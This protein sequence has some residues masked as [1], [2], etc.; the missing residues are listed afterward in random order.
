MLPA[1]VI[2]AAAGSGKSS[3]FAEKL[4]QS[5]RSPIEVYVPT[6]KLA[7][8][9][10][11]NILRH[12]PSKSIVILRGR[13]AL[14]ADGLPLCSKHEIADQ[15]V[16]AGVAVYPHL[17]LVRGE[18]NAPTIRCEYYDQCPYIQQFRL[19]EIIIYTHAHIPLQRSALENWVP[20]AV[21]I[22]ESFFQTCI[23]QFRLPLSLLTHPSLPVP[24]RALCRDIAEGFTQGQSVHGRV[25]ESVFSDEFHEAKKALQ[26]TSSSLT[27]GMTARHQKKLIQQI[28]NFSPISVLLD[29]L[30]CAAGLTKPPQSI[31]FDHG[32]G[33]LTI[34]HRHRITRFDRKDG[35]HPSIH[36][37][38]ASAAKTIIGRFF[39][40]RRFELI[41]TARNAH[42]TQ[43]S[44][45][46][47][48][49]TSLVPNSNSDAGSAKDAQTRL[50]EIE[51]LVSRLAENHQKVLV[52]GPV[53]IV[54]NPKTGAQPLISIPAHCELAHFNAL[55]GIDR[56]KDFDTAIVVGRNEPP[57]KAVEDMARALYYDDPEPLM[58]TG[59]WI[60][61]VRG[62]RIKGQRTGTD[63]NIHADSRVQDVLEQLREYEN[64]QAVDRL[65][66]VHCKEEKTLILLSNIPLDIDVDELRSWNEIMLGTR[67]ERA[68]DAVDGVLP[69]SAAWLSSYFPELWATQEAAKKDVDRAFKRGQTSNRI[70][71]RKM[72]PFNI[73]YKTARQRRWSRSLSR[74]DDEVYIKYELE[75]LV[76][77]PVTVKLLHPQL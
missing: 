51:A 27:P 69:L 24:L 25:L 6:H 32:N 74:S 18:N 11:D 57:T 30:A 43:C 72:S 65:R 37:L 71:I 63:V 4:A 60:Q 58:L 62:Y 33:V 9:W 40:V 20:Y 38:D 10:R 61:G 67:M 39:E 66:L 12:N 41:A 59:E 50:D 26:Q 44:S 16:H 17:C 15:L 68:W 3:A 2:K 29:H 5:H 73:E 55:R 13:N 14:S 46:R 28:I 22:D 48:S 1:T 47:C 31:E 19:A 35:T 77:E 45:V 56:W 23:K 7:E 70:I 36:I 49:T 52:V 21:I 75:R 53:A 64:L 8:E 42:V 34:H 76:G 54:G